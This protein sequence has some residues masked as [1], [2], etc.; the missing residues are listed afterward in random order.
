[1][2]STW[3]E[4]F[5]APSGP[6]LHADMPGISREIASSRRIRV[7][8][9]S[10]I[11]VDVVIWWRQEM[12]GRPLLVRDEQWLREELQHLLGRLQRRVHLV[13]AQVRQK[14]LVA[15]VFEQRLL[16][17]PLVVAQLVVGGAPTIGLEHQ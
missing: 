6:R 2:A 7:G 3:S 5:A 4:G 15:A 12:K 14:E 8:R 9:G 10:E 17:E 11:T 16:Y 1:M 13:V